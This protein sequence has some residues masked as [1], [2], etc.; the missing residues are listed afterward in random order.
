MPKQMSSEWLTEFLLPALT[1]A[2]DNCEDEISLFQRAV[3]HY[4]TLGMPATRYPWLGT[5]VTVVLLCDL[6]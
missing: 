5:C 3:A 2:Q 6:Q 1:L 4:S